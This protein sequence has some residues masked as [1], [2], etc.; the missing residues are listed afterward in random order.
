MY[1]CYPSYCLYNRK[2]MSKRPLF[3]LI[4]TAG[5]FTLFTQLASGDVFENTVQV[6]WRLTVATLGMVGVG[7]AG[8]LVRVLRKSYLAAKRFLD[9]V[10][11][12]T[13]LIIA[14]PI[15]VVCG[16][17]IRVDSAGPIFYRQRRLGRYGVPFTIYKLRTM[18][19]DAEGRSGPVWAGEDDARV[20]RVGRFMR[21]RRIDEI[22]QLWNVLKGDMSLVG[23][24]P[25]RPYFTRQITLVAPR[26]TER[27]KVRPGISG[28]AQ[29]R[30]RYGASI[31]D[32]ER[33]LRFDLLYCR[34]M[35]LML[36]LRILIATLGCVVRGAG[37]R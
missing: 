6:S 29:V 26:F 20:T 25:E 19:Q 9:I 28:L 15:I 5:L 16:I 31:R 3:L 17:L 24:R 23:P 27:L 22:P 4:A 33:K 13:G 2:Y 8:A 10:L 37:A 1:R 36:D 14:A 11:A 32:A 21:S 18:R 34:R 35:C 7:V 12:L 30:Y